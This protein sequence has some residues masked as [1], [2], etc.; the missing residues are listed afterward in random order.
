MMLSKYD[1]SGHIAKHG[2]MSNSLMWHHHGEVQAP[3]TAESDGSDVEDQM[4]DIIADIGMEYDLG[5]RDQHPLPEV[6]NFYRLLATLDEKVHDGTDLT[7][8]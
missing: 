5:S 7:I 8:L 4:D 3:A 2:F 6:E 1:M